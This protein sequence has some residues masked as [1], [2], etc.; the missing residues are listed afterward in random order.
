MKP[1]KMIIPDKLYVH[2]KEVDCEYTNGSILLAKGFPYEPD[3]SDF[4]E[5]QAS[6]K[7]WA[8]GSSSF[9]AMTLRNQAHSSPSVV[10]SS[11]SMSGRDVLLMKGPRNLSFKLDSDNML[12]LLRSGSFEKGEFQGDVVLAYDRSSSMIR[13]VHAG[14]NLHQS[15]ERNT[16]IREADRMS[17]REVDRGDTVVLKDGSIANYLGGFYL[18]REWARLQYQGRNQGWG[19]SW[20]GPMVHRKYLYRVYDHVVKHRHPEKIRHRSSID[21]REI[22]EKS[23]DA[24]SKDRA[25]RQLQSYLK[26]PSCDL[27]ESLH[28]RRGSG[29]IVFASPRKFEEDDVDSITQHEAS[30][31]RNGES[32]TES[33]VTE[34]KLQ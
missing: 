30:M 31:T 33:I 5:R 29:I 19:R 23:D 20:K 32:W 4:E 12:H 21:I 14:S 2:P 28:A 25:R 17:L 22:E 3:D 6:L 24:W 15:I 7:R 13:L 8:S 27:D 34:S 9:G 16:E 26:R 11:Q 18:Y 10:D 1:H